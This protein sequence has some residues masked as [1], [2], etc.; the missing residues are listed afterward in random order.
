M[1]VPSIVIDSYHA[2]PCHVPVAGDLIGYCVQKRTAAA[3]QAGVK[4]ILYPLYPCTS[5]AKV[6]AHT[7]THTEIETTTP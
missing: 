2:L 4:V 3:G 5:N 1:D 7:H 6:N